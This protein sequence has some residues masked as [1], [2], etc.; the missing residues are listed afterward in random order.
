MLLLT[1][2]HIVTD[3]WSIGVLLPRARRPLRRSPAGCPR[4]CPSCRVQYADYAAW[5]RRVAR[6]ERARAPAR[7]LEARGW[8]ARPP[9]LELPTD[10]PRPRRRASGA[11][12]HAAFA[13]CCPAPPARGAAPAAGRHPL[14]GAA[15]RLPGAARTATPGQDD[16]LRRL[17]RSPTG[18]RPRVEALIGFFVN[19]LL[20]RTDLSGDPT[21][22]RAAGPRCSDATLD[23]YAHQDLPFER[24]GRGAAARARPQPLRRSSR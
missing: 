18:A 24:A 14:H 4:R 6:G 1:M 20:L 5:Q 21:L 12:V 17:A 11:S 3:G 16:M 8:P 13:R 15:G 2:H 7:L 9:P 10:R 23:A 22:P 19:T